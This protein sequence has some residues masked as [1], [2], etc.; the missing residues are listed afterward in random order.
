MALDSGRRH[1]PRRLANGAGL[2][3]GRCVPGPERTFTT[4]RGV[5]GPTRASRLSVRDRPVSWTGPEFLPSF[6]DSRGLVAVS[7][8]QRPRR[9]HRGPRFPSFIWTNP[10]P[11]PLRRGHGR[12][13]RAQPRHE[14]RPVWQRS[15]MRRCVDQTEAGNLWVRNLATVAKFVQV[16]RR[17]RRR[18]SERWL[19]EHHGFRMP[20]RAWNNLAAASRRLD[21]GPRCVR[22]SMNPCPGRRVPA[23]TR[24]SRC[25]PVS[26]LRLHPSARS[27][28]R[29]RRGPDPRLLR[30]AAGEG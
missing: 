7:R 28:A 29:S 20:T 5:V 3:P 12:S 8:V 23:P 19:I 26:P 6:G 15:R 16:L 2:I 17:S 4:E 9:L 21:A 13:H 25:R 11:L 1:R 14:P 18:C 27:A 24:P 30:P 22:I 10:I